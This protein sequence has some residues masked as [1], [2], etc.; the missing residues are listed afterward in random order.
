MVQSE[1]VSDL[2]HMGAGRTTCS[3]GAP[4]RREAE[5]AARAGDAR[6]EDRLDLGGY[7]LAIELQTLVGLG[8]RQ[9]LDERGSRAQRPHLGPHLVHELL[10][11]HAVP[12]GG[13]PVRYPVA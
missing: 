9:D 7:L 4:L 3:T 6:S 12:D 5:V 11:R 1:L 2:E 8:E 13:F 10:L